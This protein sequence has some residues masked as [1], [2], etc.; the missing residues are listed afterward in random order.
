MKNTCNI[1]MFRVHTDPIV[2]TSSHEPGV[3]GTRH[4]L[5]CPKGQTTLGFKTLLETVCSLHCIQR[6][7]V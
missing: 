7:C 6:V 1:A 5:P 4:H 3:V 2:A